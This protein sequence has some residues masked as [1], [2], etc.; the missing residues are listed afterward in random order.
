MLF[1]TSV[2]SE[3]GWK[4]L[5]GPMSPLLGDNEDYNTSVDNL[6]NVFSP[7]NMGKVI[8]DFKE[9]SGANRGGAYNNYPL[10]RSNQSKHLIENFY[11]LVPWKN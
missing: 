5:G 2:V 10:R 7:T 8:T 3:Y 9:H 4:N 11:P 6:L 1:Q